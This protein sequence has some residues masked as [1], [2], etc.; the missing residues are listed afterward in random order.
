MLG[1]FAV[2][3]VFRMNVTTA[4]T[5]CAMFSLWMLVMMLF[6][7]HVEVMDL[8]T[9]LTLGAATVLT[10]FRFMR[11]WRRTTSVCIVNGFVGI[12]LAVRTVLIRL[13]LMCLHGLIP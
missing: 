1:M 6:V 4:L 10:L 5:L 13:T 12:L 8:A 7:H 3:C 11:R 9:M 2:H